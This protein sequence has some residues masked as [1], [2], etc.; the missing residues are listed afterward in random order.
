MSDRKGVPITITLT[1]PRRIEVSVNLD[2]VQ[3]FQAV[4]AEVPF[5]EFKHSY[6]ELAISNM[7]PG[8]LVSDSLRLLPDTPDITDSGVPVFAV[9]ANIVRG[10]VLLALYLH[11]SVADLQG[12]ADIMRLMSG[13]P[14]PRELKEIDLAAHAEA[15]SETREELTRSKPTVSDY[16]EHPD[17]I[18]SRMR[19]VALNSAISDTEDGCCRILAFDLTG[20]EEAKN[21]INERWHCILDNGPKHISAFDCLATILWKAVGR[22]S[23]PQGPLDKNTNCLLSLR[24]HINIRKHISPPMLPEDYFGNAVVHADVHLGIARLATAYDLSSLA[25]HAQQIRA[26]IDQV[27]EHVVRAKIDALQ[28]AHD[29]SKATISSRKLD[30][31]LV[32]TSWADLPTSESEAGLGLDLGAPQFGRKIGRSH[33]AFGC[34]VLPVSREEGFWEV[35]VT[36]TQL[37]MAHLLT[38]ERLMRFVN[39]VI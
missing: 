19:S 4:V 13:S 24:I 15:Q 26:A 6:E 17:Y 8:L 5:S 37:V 20:I 2:D 39:H 10:G 34:L 33:S 35:Q 32:I 11:H 28:W 21:E 29:P 18:Q 27:D 1:L 25:H 36:L 22:A 23:W 3:Q 7:P 38:D 12:L 30:T 14:Q 9:L 16:T 31:N